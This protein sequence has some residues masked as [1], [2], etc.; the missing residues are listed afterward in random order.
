MDLRK[1]WIVLVSFT[2]KLLMKVFLK[3]LKDSSDSYQRHNPAQL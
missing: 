3:L 2:R 1:I